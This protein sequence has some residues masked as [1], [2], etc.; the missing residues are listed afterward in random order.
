MKKKKINNIKYYSKI[1]FTNGII[2]IKNNNSY[3]LYTI[4]NKKLPIFQYIKLLLNEN[5]IDDII[6]NIN[7]LKEAFDFWDTHKIKKNLNTS[8]FIN[9]LIKYFWPSNLNILYFKNINNLTKINSKLININFSNNDF[10][11]NL[12]NIIKKPLF[13]IKINKDLKLFNKILFRYKYISALINQSD[14]IILYINKIKNYSNSMSIDCSLGKPLILRRNS[15]VF[16]FI[17][18]LSIIKK[19]ILQIK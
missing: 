6:I 11:I 5:Y 1:L 4:E 10:I 7:K 15:K 12:L 3:K 8:Y 14:K 17:N 2:I 9:L 18:L 16:N 13:S 19:R